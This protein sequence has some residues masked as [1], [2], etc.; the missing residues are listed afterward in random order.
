MPGNKSIRFPRLHVAASV[1]NRILNVADGIPNGNPR[2]VAPPALPDVPLEGA[3][4]DAKL[5]TPPAPAELPE[6]GEGALL[7]AALSGDDL[8]AAAV[9]PLIAPE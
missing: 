3:V 8:G 6:G 7:G 2:A 9:S 4:L 5:N 1:T